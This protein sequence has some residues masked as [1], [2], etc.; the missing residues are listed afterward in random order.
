MHRLSAAL[1]MQ[2]MARVIANVMG[3]MRTS[4]HLEV[5]APTGIHSTTSADA[6]SALSA[7]LSLSFNPVVGVVVK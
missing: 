4:V 1:I 2:L 3:F 7:A 5:C 6:F